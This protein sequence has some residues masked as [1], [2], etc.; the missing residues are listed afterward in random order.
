MKENLKLVSEIIEQFEETDFYTLSVRNTSIELQGKFDSDLSKKLSSIGFLFTIC[1]KN[2]FV[3][4]S[5][6]NITI[7]LT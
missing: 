5:K 3:T 1:E 6:E 2:G 4:F 7:T